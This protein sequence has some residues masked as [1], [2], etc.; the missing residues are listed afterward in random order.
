M[1]SLYKRILVLLLILTCYLNFNFKPYTYAAESN[2]VIYNNLK[3]KGDFYCDRED[4]RNAVIYYIKAI[5]LNKNEADFNKLG[6]ICYIN[7][8]YVH[9]LKFFEKA[10]EM[11]PENIRTKKKIEFIKST[12][13]EIKKNKEAKITTPKETAPLRLHNL[14]EIHGKLKNS[15]NEKK[16][17]TI[18]DFIWSDKEGK[19]LLETIINKRTPIYLDSKAQYSNVE[20]INLNYSKIKLVGYDKLPESYSNITTVN[21]VH[22]KEKDIS[23][24]NEQNIASS[25]NTVPL[26]VVCH[27]LCHIIKT[28]NYPNS[29]NS[30][31]EEMCASIFGYN[32]AS[33]IL[34][35]EELQED[36]IKNL[37]YLH[38]NTTFTNPDSI[39]YNL[40]LKDNFVEKMADLGIELPY[41]ALYSDVENLRLKEAKDNI[42][43]Q[44]YIK[45]LN[46]YLST[47][48]DT[49]YTNKYTYIRYNLFM[50]KNGNIVIQ[51]Q[52]Y[53]NFLKT[54]FKEDIFNLK[55]ASSNVPFPK[56]YKDPIIHLTIYHSPKKV[57]IKFRT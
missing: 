40:Q 56:N 53:T 10:Q 30:Q 12:V 47:N 18:L 32:T 50:N 1:K 57:K 42:E 46:D 7:N 51:R 9:S 45:E 2:T 27:E 14:V 52:P 3:R 15:E 49:I 13:T 26:M 24:F 25:Q 4:F 23:W 5:K 44:H 54:I 36:Q 17:H 28:M 22:I 34:K 55:L 31:E 43:L 20:T 38:Y 11:D 48:Y 39:Y 19:I 16:L 8:D 29:K 41:S 6:L 33:R 35:G 21:G 37:A